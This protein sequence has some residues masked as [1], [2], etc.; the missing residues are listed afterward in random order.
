M[1][2]AATFGLN[3]SSRDLKPFQDISQ[4]VWTIGLPAA[5]N[6]ADV[7]LVFGGDGT[8]HRHLA[9]LVELGLPVLMVPAGSGNDFARALNLHSVRDSL[10]AFKR[11][12]AGPSNVRRVVLEVVTPP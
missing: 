7:I 10:G 9:G 3:S 5:A 2:A 4:A 6:E 8:V 12:A 1:R 11:F